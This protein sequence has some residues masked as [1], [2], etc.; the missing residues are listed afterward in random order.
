MTL[1]N[2]EITLPTG[3]YLALPPDN[4]SGPGI[5]LFH[6]WWG[7]TADT[8][9]IA[10]NLAAQGYCVLAVNMYGD[11]QGTDD[12]MLAE[13]RYM[14]MNPAIAD[15]RIKAGAEKLSNHPACSAL[16]AAIGYSMGGQIA[17]YAAS[18]I[19]PDL[20]ACIAFYPVHPAFE[21]QPEKMQGKLVCFFAEKDEYSDEQTMHEFLAG[22][23]YQKAELYTFPD[24]VHGFFNSSHPEVYHQQ[25]AQKAWQHML[26]ILTDTRPAAEAGA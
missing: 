10:Q 17:F 26:N 25:A 21:P 19:V 8:I 16:H 4:Q 23:Q 11:L 14:S 5:L 9:T 20:N 18:V 3:D 13:E 2:N 15:R 7:I 1:Q 24:T 6:E 22:H 12:P